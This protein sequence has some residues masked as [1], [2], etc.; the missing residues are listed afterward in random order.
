MTINGIWRTPVQWANQVAGGLAGA[1]LALRLYPDAALAARLIERIGFLAEHGQ[2]PAGFF[3]G[4]NGMDINYNFEVMLPELAEIY[5]L[6]GNRD[7][8][9][10]ARRFTEWFGYHPAPRAGRLGLAHLPRHVRPDQRRLLRQR[11][12]RPGPQQPW[13]DLHPRPAE[14]RRVL[15]LQ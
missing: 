11:D 6:T 14:T 5:L 4:P 1:A 12:S 10:M 3:Y 2:S 8:L 7:V 15:H 13:L 9:G